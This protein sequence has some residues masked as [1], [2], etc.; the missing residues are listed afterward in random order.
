MSPANIL[1]VRNLRDAVPV[2]PENLQLR[3]IALAKRHLVGEESWS[4]QAKSHKPSEVGYQV[5]VRTQARP[6]K[7]RWEQSGV[8]VEATENNSYLVK[9]DGVGRFS[10]RSNLF[11]SFQCPQDLSR[12]PGRQE[13]VSLVQVLLR[14]W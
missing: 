8:V 11:P 1:F 12:S 14:D 5:M 10:K 2:A 6:T 4:H 9:L 3:E 7:G 13:D